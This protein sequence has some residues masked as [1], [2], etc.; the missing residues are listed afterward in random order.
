MKGR[1]GSF[2]VIWGQLL[3]GCL[4]CGLFSVCEVISSQT[5]G[6]IC[7]TFVVYYISYIQLNLGYC[8]ESFSTSGQIIETVSWLFFENRKLKISEPKV[9]IVLGEKRMQFCTVSPILSFQKPTRFLMRYFSTSGFDV[10]YF[11][12]PENSQFPVLTFRPDVE[13]Y[14]MQ[15]PG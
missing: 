13:K 2:K 15:Q 4:R 6:P 12:C 3:K 10:F 1:L 11:R 9:E 7:T 8:M 5:G 14:L